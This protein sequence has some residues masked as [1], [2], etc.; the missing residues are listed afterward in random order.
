MISHSSVSSDHPTLLRHPTPGLLGWSETV[1]AGA[2]DDYRAGQDS[3]RWTVRHVPTGELIY[4]GPGP[5]EI[6]RSPAP[7]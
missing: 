1:L 7:Y 6:V 5:V 3:N 2:V 4:S